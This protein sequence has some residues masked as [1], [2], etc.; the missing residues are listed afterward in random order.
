MER[1]KRAIYRRRCRPRPRD[2]Y[3]LRARGRLLP[4]SP[5]A[6]V[7]TR[8]FELS[9]ASP[10]LKK[11]SGRVGQSRC[12]NCLLAQSSSGTE[13]IVRGCYC[14]PQLRN[15]KSAILMRLLDRYVIGN[16]L[17]AYIY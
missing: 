4:P 1:D 6:A 7:E 17:Q 14:N 3:L 11:W 10:S 5:V 2:V 9:T 8:S 12:L 13:F 15:P 16:F